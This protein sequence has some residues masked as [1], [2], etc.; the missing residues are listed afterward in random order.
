M[1]SF[2]SLESDT[3]ACDCAV[4]HSL[5]WSAMMLERV[6]FGHLIIG[7]N[8]HVVFSNF[9]YLVLHLL[10]HKSIINIIVRTKLHIV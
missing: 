2:S 8:S 5:G 4:T 6:R 1:R 9:N 10:H 3:G 7:I